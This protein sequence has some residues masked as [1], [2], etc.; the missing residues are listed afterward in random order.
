[1]WRSVLAD[2]LEMPL[3][4]ADRMMLSI[5]PEP[6]EDRQLVAWAARLRDQDPG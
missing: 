4:N 1:M 5:L 2:R 6:G 3:I